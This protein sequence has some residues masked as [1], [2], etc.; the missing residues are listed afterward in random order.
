MAS[1]Q[2]PLTRT[3][4]RAL[5]AALLVI[6]LAA[7]CLGEA[8][9]PNLTTDT[10][11]SQFTTETAKLAFLQRYLKLATPVQAAEF[12]IIYHDNSGGFVPGPSDWNIRVLLKVAPADIDRWTT[13]MQ[14]APS[15]QFDLTWAKA[16]AAQHPAWTMTSE[17]EI[18]QKP[19]MVLAL[20][21]PEKI[22]FV[23]MVT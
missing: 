21:R 9:R 12:H 7:G 14:P 17:P 19:G 18:Y 22:I 23:R 3:V 10:Q 11:S 2:Q 8:A 4:N 1:L 13:G 6:F 15:D 16:F 5:L 20:F